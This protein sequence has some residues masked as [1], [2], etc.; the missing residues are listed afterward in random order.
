MKIGNKITEALP[1][2]TRESPIQKVILNPDSAPWS[3]DGCWSNG[4]SCFYRQQMM[5]IK[6]PRDLAQKITFYRNMM[7]GTEYPELLIVPARS[8]PSLPVHFTSGR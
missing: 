8:G 7:I 3:R 6:P 5:N 2:I 1:G 4:L